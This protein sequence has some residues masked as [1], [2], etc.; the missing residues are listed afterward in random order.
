[1]N[2]QTISAEASAATAR[3]FGSWLRRY[4]LAFFLGA[5][6][7]SLVLGPLQ[8]AARDGDLLE[9]TQWTLVMLTGLWA[10]GGRP[11]TLVWGILLV[12]PA[13]A[14]KWVNHWQP[15]L[16][17]DSFF[18]FPA[19]LFCGFFVVCLLRFILRAPRV[20]SEVLCAGV[21]GYLMLGVL[22]SL[23]YII[24]GRLAGDSF[25]FTVGREGQ[26]MK[27][28]TAIYYSFVTLTT[29]GYGDIVPVSGVARMVAMTESTTGTLY[30]AVMI[31][32][33]VALYYAPNAAPV[34]CGPGQNLISPI[35]SIPTALMT[36]NQT[37]TKNE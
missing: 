13:L 29:V 35:D 37:I 28:F 1:M 19:I 15:G 6:G 17:P 22:W 11:R 27:G 30:M 18:L 12:T 26:G 24:T 9:S 16:V 8:E 23:T 4:P 20:D 21:A 31:A 14:S 7:V 3:R 5:L 33:L 34:S 10:L 2:S 32:R 25:A 36:I